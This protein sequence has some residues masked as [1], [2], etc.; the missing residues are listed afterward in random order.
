M[1]N[2]ENLRHLLLIKNR[3]FAQNSKI[4]EK[5]QKIPEI[6]DFFKELRQSKMKE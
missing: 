6:D 5:L 4:F 2:F 1:E 3:N